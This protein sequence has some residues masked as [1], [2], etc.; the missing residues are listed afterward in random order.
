MCLNGSCNFRKSNAVI[1]NLQNIRRWSPLNKTNPNACSGIECYD[2]DLTRLAFTVTL[3]ISILG[4]IGN[5]VSLVVILN[6]RLRKITNNILIAQL[7]LVNFMYCALVLPLQATEFHVRGNFL[8]SSLCQY[9][10][11]FKI[12]LAGSDFFFISAIATYRLLQ[13]VYNE[14]FQTLSEKFWFVLSC[15]TCYVFPAAYVS[16]PILGIFGTYGYDERMAQCTL[17]YS[18]PVYP[19]ILFFMFGALLP[20]TIVV[21]CYFRIAIY[22]RQQATALEGENKQRKQRMQRATRRFYILI[23]TPVFTYL[24]GVT[25]LTLLFIFDPELKRALAHL[26]SYFMLWTTYMLNPVV[27]SLMD[28]KFQ[29]ASIRLFARAGNFKKES[30][31]VRKTHMFPGF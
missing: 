21:G 9:M 1:A 27:Y 23:C 8:G 15:V 24:L 3:V 29:R 28:L 19:R 17:S 18:G 2:S 5:C 25:P 12:W 10:A 16:V 4:S 31:A 6:S 7:N 26:W 11:G 13:V 30:I 22:V 14:I 20:T